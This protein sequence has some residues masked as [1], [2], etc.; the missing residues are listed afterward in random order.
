[1]FKKLIVIMSV[2]VFMFSAFGCGNKNENEEQNTENQVEYEVPEKADNWKLAV[3]QTAEKYAGRTTGEIVFYG[4][5]NFTLWRSME[6][7]MLPYI[8][9]NHGFGGSTDND[10]MAF[11]DELLYPF[12]PSVVFFQ[13]GSNDNAAGMTVD[14]IITNK[15]KMYSMFRQKLPDTVFIVMSGL[16]L[17]GRSEYWEDI[18]E[19]NQA[20]KEYCESNE[21]MYFADAT[22]FMLDENGDFRPELF[23]D[24]GVHLNEDGHALWTELMKEILEENID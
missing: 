2:F 3:K 22:S 14:E 6:E 20:L 18:N 8:V 15:D 19:T 17:P 9:Q 23:I 12:E 7:D 5:S 4:A 21:N 13:T 1:M 11:A 24:D 16:P 10:L